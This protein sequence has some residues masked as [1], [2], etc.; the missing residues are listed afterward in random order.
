[1]EDVL[2]L[3]YGGSMS[4]LSAGS[5]LFGVARCGQV[6]WG[7]TIPDSG[8]RILSCQ[9]G[10]LPQLREIANGANTISVMGEVVWICVCVWCGEGRQMLF[11]D[12]GHDG[13]GDAPCLGK[14]G[15]KP[16]KQAPPQ[17]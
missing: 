15:H 1:M 7:L 9:G 10:F 16:P 4:A 8:I 17:G 5:V 3:P 14:P 12:R 6:R 2:L 13:F 11:P